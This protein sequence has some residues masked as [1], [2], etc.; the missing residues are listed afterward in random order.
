MF[1]DVAAHRL[2]YVVVACL[3]RMRW[4]VGSY[5]SHLSSIVRAKIK[6]LS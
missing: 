2:I 3:A 4:V 5:V 1:V 6:Y